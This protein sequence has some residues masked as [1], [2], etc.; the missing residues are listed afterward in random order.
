MKQ[1]IKPNRFLALCLFGALALVLGSIAYPATMQVPKGTELKVKLVTDAELKSDKTAKDTSIPITLVDPVVIGGKTVVEAGA[2]GTAKVAE[3]QKAGDGKPGVIKIA[4]VELEPKGN[5]VSPT[6][7]KI[8]LGGG[9]EAQGKKKKSL[10]VFGKLTEG[11]IS[12]TETYKA[13]VAES[14]VLESK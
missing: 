10:F 14:I 9:I 8:K 5:Y 7:A 4:F 2:T 1:G 6:G 13:T 12:T 11:K 3:V